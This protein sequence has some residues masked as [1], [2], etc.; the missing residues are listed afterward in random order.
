M[1]ESE[2]SD[3]SAIEI[4][5]GMQLKTSWCRVILGS[6]PALPTERMIMKSSAM[7]LNSKWHTTWIS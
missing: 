5:T 1:S 7:Q 4:S 3:D 6:L 2:I